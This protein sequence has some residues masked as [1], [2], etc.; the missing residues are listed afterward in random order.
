MQELLAHGEQIVTSAWLEERCPKASLIGTI[1]DATGQVLF[2]LFRPTED[3]VRYLLLL[4][5][6]AATC[7]LPR[8]IYHD[9]HTILRSPKQSTLDDELAGRPPRSKMQ[10]MMAQLGI[11]SITAHSPQAKGRIERLW[12]TLQECLTKELRLAGVTTL[13]D[14]NTF[15]QAS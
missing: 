2:L 6:I 15:L 7:G 5:T 10:R 12:T 11:E 13:Q 14:A 1:D 9:R 8:S 4:R 3:K